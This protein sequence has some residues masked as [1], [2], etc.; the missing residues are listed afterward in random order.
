MRPERPVLIEDRLA[1][2]HARRRSRRWD[3][4]RRG[5][6]ARGFRGA[7]VSASAA[8]GHDSCRVRPRGLAPDGSHAHL[9]VRAGPMTVYVLDPLA[10]TDMATT[11]AAAH[12][13]GAHLL[14]VELP[15]PQPGHGQGAA[16]PLAQ[17]V[18]EGRQWWNI[19]PPQGA[20]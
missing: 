20:Q 7:L 17:V 3:A 6:S 15:V 18:V 5:C 16:Y 8:A 12:V 11:W 9:L 4:R 14:P 19:R 2:A 1:R 13:R 10:L